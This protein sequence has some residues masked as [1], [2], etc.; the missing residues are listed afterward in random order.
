MKRGLALL[1][2]PMI[3]ALACSSPNPMIHRAPTATMTETATLTGTPA[4]TA[5]ITPTREPTLTPPPAATD[6]C[7]PR[8]DSAETLASIQKKTA[9]LVP[10]TRAIWYDDF[11][12]EDFSYGWGTAHTNPTMAIDVSGGFLT[13]TAKEVKDVYDG[14]GRTEW[15]LGNNSGML[16]LFRIQAGI[17]ANLY[18]NTG[19]W[20]TP[21]F[22]RW[23]LDINPT[24]LQETIWEGWEGTGWL[25][26]YFPAKVLRPGAWYYLLIRLGDAGQV[27]MKIWERDNPANHADFMRGM[28]PKWSG[29]RW[30]TM[31]QVYRGTLE[32][33]KYWEMALDQA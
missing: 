21:D 22:R 20:Q 13:I 27:T 14:I 9:E 24:S 29:L 3:L 32:M 33:D 6:V 18:I 12:C 11:L 1:F 28:G 31:L 4:P 10:G 16:M 8:P 5:T 26:G 30:L 2:T 15:N 7:P 19:T 25:S 23:G 17:S